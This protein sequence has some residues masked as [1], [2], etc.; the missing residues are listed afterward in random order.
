[1]TNMPD[2]P[3]TKAKEPK[4]YNN[5]DPKNNPKSK[6]HEEEPDEVEVLDEKSKPASSW[7]QAL[8]DLKARAVVNFLTFCANK[9][10]KL[11]LCW[12]LLWLKITI[13]F[14]F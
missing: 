5:D 4:I 7:P 14:K 6:K 2:S 12:A 13:I 8:Q 10:N 1:M 3:S 11:A 9:L